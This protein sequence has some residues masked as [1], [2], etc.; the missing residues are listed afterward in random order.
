MAV[1]LDPYQVI[2]GPLITEKLTKLNEQNNIFGFK[3]D[4]RANKIQIKQA[5]ETIWPDVDVVSVNTQLRKGKPRRVR[6]HW[7]KSPDW[8]RALVKLA[9]GQ[10]IE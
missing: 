7:T 5:I 6:F 3:V 9:E 8:K 4:R 1:E 2:R 10:R